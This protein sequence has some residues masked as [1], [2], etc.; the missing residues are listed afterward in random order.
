MSES[1]S[2]VTSSDRKD[3]KPEKP[4]PDFPLFPHASGRWAKKILG[5]FHYFGKWQDG[6]QA[7][8]DLYNQQKEALHAGRRIRDT[9][10]TG[11]NI[12][13]L[14]NHFLNEKRALM[15]SGE[16]SPVTFLFYRR[17]T[18]KI[19]DH[20]GKSRVVS[21]VGIDDFSELRAKL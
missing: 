17:T 20:L 15:G 18:D 16:L 8:L 5:K 10:P 4:S 13:E 19:V 6:A 9:S 2:S 1:H 11:V 3:L 14:C 7:A 12:R 21:D